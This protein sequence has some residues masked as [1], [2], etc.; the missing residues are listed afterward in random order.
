MRAGVLAGRC[1]C[2]LRGGD[3]ELLGVTHH[4]QS[5]RPGPLSPPSRGP[6]PPP[7]F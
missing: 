5:V 7:P 1:G 2:A 6:R 3:V 4:A